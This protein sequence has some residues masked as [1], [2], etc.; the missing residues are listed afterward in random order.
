MTYKIGQKVKVKSWKELKKIPG[1][2]Q[3]DG[4]LYFKGVFFTAEMKRYC[5]Q[6]IIITAFTKTEDK[7]TYYSTNDNK[8][9]WSWYSWMFEDS[10]KEMLN[11]LT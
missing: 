11:T 2:Y 6:Y 9:D 5:N 8:E 7:G 4:D 1:I 10:L 3:E